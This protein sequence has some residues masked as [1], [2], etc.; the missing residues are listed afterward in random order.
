LIIGNQLPGLGQ[1]HH[2]HRLADEGIAQDYLLPS[3][4]VLFCL[5]FATAHRVGSLLVARLT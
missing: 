5:G 1:W 3:V 2:E 4:L